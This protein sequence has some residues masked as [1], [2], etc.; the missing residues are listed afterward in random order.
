MKYIISLTKSLFS[1]IKTIVSALLKCLLAIFTFLADTAK[2]PSPYSGRFLTASEKRALLKRKHKGVVLGDSSQRLSLNNSFRNLA[3]F[4]NVGSG[5]SSTVIIPTLLNL[6]TSCVCLDVG[7]TLYAKT[8][9]Y[10]ASKGFTIKRIDIDNAAQSERYNPLLRCKSTQAIKQLAH[11]LITTALPNKEGDP[12]WG[13]SSQQMLF[14]LIKT[15][16]HTAPEQYHNLANVWHLLQHLSADE[17]SKAYQWAMRNADE[18]LYAEWKACFASTAEKTIDNTLLSVKAALE[19]IADPNLAQLT[20]SDT[21]GD[22]SSL[23]REKKTVLY[24]SVKESSLRYHA[25]ILSLLLNDIFD[26]LQESGKEAEQAVLL[27]LDEIGHIKT[28]SLVTAINTLRKK[29]VG[30]VL[31]LQAKSQLAAQ[32]GINDA[33]SII[34]GGCGTQLFLPGINNVRQAEEL[35]RMIGLKTF[36]TAD[37]NSVA[38]P[39]LSVDQIMSAKQSLFLHAGKR[40]SRLPLKPYYKQYALL[41]KSKYPAHPLPAAAT[42]QSTPLVSL[43]SL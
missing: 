14:T 32:F 15:L 30:M 8:S 31:C 26:S 20:A 42:F 18:N 33:A 7:N 41:E 13:L 9:G 35:S 16:L 10:L 36:E 39:V 37:G 28:P 23:L 29:E 24:I 25:F 11:T 34:E 2:P 5:K 1:G 3:V 38:R 4:G 17:H 27:L 21:L 6:E 12:F 40:L 22:F 43:T 19:K